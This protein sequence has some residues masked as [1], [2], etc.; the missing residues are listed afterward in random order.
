MSVLIISTLGSFTPKPTDHRGLRD[1]GHG[2][3]I[4]RLHHEAGAFVP[5][6]ESTRIFTLVLALVVPAAN[7]AKAFQSRDSNGAVR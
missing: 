3:I 5:P 2:H 4:I 1:F 6:E 7:A